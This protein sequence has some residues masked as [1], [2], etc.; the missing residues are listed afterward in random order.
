VI[1]IKYFGHFDRQGIELTT[2]IS[3]VCKP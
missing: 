1:E 3:H 2:I